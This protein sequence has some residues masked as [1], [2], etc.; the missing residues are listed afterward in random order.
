MSR[1]FYGSININEVVERLKQQ[2]SAFVKGQNGKYYCNVSLWL[3]DEPDQ[4]GNVL[5]IKLS[6]TAKTLEEDKEQGKIYIGNCKESES[7]S[8][9]IT[10]KDAENF[11]DVLDDLPF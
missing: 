5:S 11:T 2:H 1:L 7:I 9:P 10:P 3:N 8:K 6:A 4:Y